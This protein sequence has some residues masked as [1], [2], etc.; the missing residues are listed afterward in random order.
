LNKRLT[1]DFSETF[2]VDSHVQSKLEEWEKE[3]DN[4]G[5]EFSISGLDLHEKSGA[6]LIKRK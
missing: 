5:L 3:F 1:I 2:L 4:Q 6:V